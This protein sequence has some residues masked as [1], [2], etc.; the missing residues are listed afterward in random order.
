MELHSYL[1]WSGSGYLGASWSVA[2]GRWQ[3]VASDIDRRRSCQPAH[4]AVS[5]LAIQCD[6]GAAH[7]LGAG[8]EV[9]ESCEK[10]RMLG[11]QC[12]YF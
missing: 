12:D 9:R 3:R 7:E 11:I 5:F 10:E 4:R 2:S 6:G 1:P 8:E